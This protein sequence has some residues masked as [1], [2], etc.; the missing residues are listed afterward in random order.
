MAKG[1]DVFVLDMGS[2]IKIL[3]LA[4]KMVRI[5]GLKPFLEEEKNTNPGDIEIKITGLRD[6]EK[7]FEEL[8]IG[9]NSKDTESARK[10]LLSKKWKIK[11]SVKLISLIEKKK[12]ITTYQLSVEQVS[13][14]LELRLQKLTAYGIGEMRIYL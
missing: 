10:S 12:N 3:E 7:L 2:P 4:E 5:H 13:A 8:L 6:G 1:G 9:E 11:K 14:I